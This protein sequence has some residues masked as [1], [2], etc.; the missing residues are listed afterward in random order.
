M[1]ALTLGKR[2][3]AVDDIYTDEEFIG[4]ANSGDR[5]VTNTGI[6]GETRIL[7]PT[8]APEGKGV[9]IVYVQ[10]DQPDGTNIPDHHT[11]RWVPRKAICTSRFGH[12]SD[13]IGHPCVFCGYEESSE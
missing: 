10:F 11:S 5:I 4:N 7:V 6:V 1:Q 13:E 12:V 3:F 2:V 9:Q 8:V